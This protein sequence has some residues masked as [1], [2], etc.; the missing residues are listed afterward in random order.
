MKHQTNAV[1]LYIVM[2][3]VAG[4]SAVAS[5]IPDAIRWV[6]DPD[7]PPH[8][9]SEERFR[10]AMDSQDGPIGSRL[11]SVLHLFPGANPTEELDMYANGGKHYTISP[12]GDLVECEP[13]STTSYFGETAK[14]LRR[15]FELA[16]GIAHVRVL[17]SKPGFAGGGAGELLDVEVIS[18][19]KDEGEDQIPRGG[20]YLFHQYA[21]MVIDGKPLC[22]G[23]H[24]I[25]NGEF[26]LFLEVV[27]VGATELDVFTLD[28]AA[29]ISTDGKVYGS[30]L[31]RWVDWHPAEVAE[32]LAAELSNR[33]A[34]Q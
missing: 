31:D 12:D 21:R 13:R 15:L 8:W 26:F 9:I 19:L 30:L 5:N 32:H 25:A 23:D 2:L 3:L 16:T 33:E 24:G 7:R 6:D 14:D 27:A 18:I 1:F 10:E 22:L 29:L 34:K 17:G 4:T 11:E 28:S 20:F